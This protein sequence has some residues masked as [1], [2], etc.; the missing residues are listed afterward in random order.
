MTFRGLARFPLEFIKYLPAATLMS[1][2]AVAMF[3]P[4][5]FLL[6]VMIPLLAFNEAKW[7]AFP[8]LVHKANAEA[9]QRLQEYCRRFRVE[10][11][12]YSSK[13]SL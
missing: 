11:N 13:D 1:C 6:P 5:F 12:K 3:P 8:E 2:Y 9:D 4:A 7:A 10:Q